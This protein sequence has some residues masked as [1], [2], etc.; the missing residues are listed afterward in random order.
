MFALLPLIHKDDLSTLL[1]PATLSLLY[2]PPLLFT[3][4][5]I[6]ALPRIY[7]LFIPYLL[8]VLL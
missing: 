2:W 6:Y 5:D 1:D 3:L 7:L 8:R 4:L